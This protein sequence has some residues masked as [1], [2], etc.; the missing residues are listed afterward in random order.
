MTTVTLVRRVPPPIVGVCGIVPDRAFE[1]FEQT[2]DWL[3]S[4]GV[5]VERVEL[6]ERFSD[7]TLSAD[8]TDHLARAGDSCLPLITVDDVVVSAGVRPTRSRL[9]RL[10]GRSRLRVG[11]PAAAPR[12]DL[13]QRGG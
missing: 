11:L 13:E 10:V 3:E 6:S 1:A 8:V 2:L 4:T 12:P 5:L 7:G 9:A